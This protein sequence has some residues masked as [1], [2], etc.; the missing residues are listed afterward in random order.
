M[1]TR[2][3]LKDFL[4]NIN[5]PKTE[6]VEDEI[7]R[8]KLEHEIGLEN[9]FSREDNDDLK[10]TIKETLSSY[11]K[12]IVDNANNIYKPNNTDYEESVYY[13]R[14]D[15]ELSTSDSNYDV[16]ITDQAAPHLERSS[17]D[18]LETNLFLDKTGAEQIKS[19]HEVLSK[20]NNEATGINSSGEATPF[21]RP[22]TFNS[23]IAA[24]Q[25]MMLDN[26][27]FANVPG[28]NNFTGDQDLSITDFEED[29]DLEE[30]SIL[31]E[32]VFGEHTK[33]NKIKLKKLKDLGASLLYRTSGFSKVNNIWGGFR[34]DDIAGIENSMNSADPYSGD[35]I[36][37][38][39]DE[40]KKQNSNSY[41]AKYSIKSIFEEISR[42]IWKVR[43]MRCVFLYNM[44]CE[45]PGTKELING[46]KVMIVIIVIL[47]L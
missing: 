14:S 24:T 18:Y 37:E 20:V 12:Y 7:L 40:Y 11:V 34:P 25:K 10:D 21:K 23:V 44:S 4:G 41:R 42:E 16:Y 33:E 8:Y 38:S 30:G 1:A 9:N 27:R 32:N 2:K 29:E 28:S 22:H 6:N 35:N 13:R 17:S 36:D 31:I 5:Y 26:N 19:G 15:P 47:H 46:D 39:N 45:E 43:S 3:T